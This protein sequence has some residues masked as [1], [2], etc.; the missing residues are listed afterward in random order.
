MTLAIFAATLLATNARATA[1]SNEFVLHSFPVSTT[2]GWEPVGNVVFKGATQLY[3]TTPNGGIN[4]RGT[5]FEIA[6][7]RGVWS[8][9]VP[10]P[11]DP[12]T[13]DGSPY[14]PG[15]LLHAGKL[16]GTTIGGSSG[17]GAV[18]ELT[19]TA[20]IGWAKTFEYSFPGFTNDGQ[21][22]NGPLVYANGNLYGTTGGGGSN[23]NC[24][25]SGENV[26]CGTVF[27][28]TPVTGGGWTESVVYNFGGTTLNTLG[29]SVPD[30]KIPVGV[31]F[32]GGSLYG[33][34]EDGGYYGEGMVFEL[35]LTTSTEIDALDFPLNEGTNTDGAV[36]ISGLAVDTA[37][38]LYGTTSQ[39]G[40]QN[41]GVVF[42][43]TPMIVRVGGI[44]RKEWTETVLHD[45]ESSVDGAYPS[46]LIL[47][48]NRNLYGTTGEDGPNSAGVA[49]ELM[50]GT[51]VP[52]TENILYSFCSLSS[53][54]DGSYPSSGLT[55]DTNHNLYG[56]TQ[57]G[58]EYGWGAVFQ[59]ILNTFALS[60]TPATISIAQGTGASSTISV[61]D[62][63]GFS[64]NV[65][66]TASGLPKGVTASFSSKI[67][68]SASTL[69]L[70]ASPTA[71]LETG[72]TV[73]ITGTS[74]NLTQTALINVSVIP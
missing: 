9:T 46:A 65:T 31:V 11:F 22:P 5:V 36:P 40:T 10:H 19:Y 67:T 32:H 4:G 63:G 51:T 59:I 68:S 70:T 64:G 62:I 60:A 8:E 57:E 58:G 50:A 52:W 61:A 30:G 2:D 16:Y 25:T 72:A 48:E 73:T 53:C 7:K 69:T 74:G 24:G 18:F 20:G 47:D 41:S 12:N 6:A 21:G 56:V 33:V 34:T 26:G 1:Q 38:N 66:L 71:K 37:G 39:G 45:F 55:F 49:F 29:T 14:S 3:G 15:L 43:L 42:E 17:Y 23:L 44:F 27:E 13:A 28:L 35:D 54:T